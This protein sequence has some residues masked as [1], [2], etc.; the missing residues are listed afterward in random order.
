MRSLD[1]SRKGLFSSQ[2]NLAAL[3]KILVVRKGPIG[4]VVVV[5]TLSAYSLLLLLS[6]DL[7]WFLYG[8]RLVSPKVA[9]SFDW[10]WTSVDVLCAIFTRRQLDVVLGWSLTFH[11]DDFVPSILT[12]SSSGGRNSC[13][14][15]SI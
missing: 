9:N 5:K 11:L 12:C 2:A 13:K 4:I 8:S 14:S 3:S 10:S 1:A 15:G 6:L 7:E